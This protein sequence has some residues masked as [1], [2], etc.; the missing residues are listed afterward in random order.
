MAVLIAS[1]LHK[2][3]LKLEL[4]NNLKYKKYINIV[5]KEQ[6]VGD[7]AHGNI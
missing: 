7:P 3:W 2:I 5:E 6:L 1:N 4:K